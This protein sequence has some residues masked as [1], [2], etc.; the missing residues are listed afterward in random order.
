MRRLEYKW[1]VGI[2]FVLGLVMQLFDITIL[3]VA[4]ATLGREFQVGE[5][6]LQWVL[7]GYMISLAV[8]I[9]SSGWLA[10]RFGSKRTFQSAVVIF[11]LASVLC[12]LSTEMWMLIAAR[13]LQGVGGGMLVPVGQAMLFRA[14][15][16]NERAKASA[17]LAIPITVAPMLGPV[18]GGALVDYASWRWI[19]FINVPVGAIALAFTVIFLREERQ[20]RPGRFDFPGF[21]FAGGG[22]ACLLYGLDRGAQSGWGAPTVWIILGAAV[23]L[24]LALIWR[25]LNTTAPML[26]VRLLGNRMFGTGNALLMCSTTAMFSMLFLIPLYLQNLRGISPMTA[27]LTLTPQA[28][29]MLLVTQVIS[30][31]YGR[32]GPRRLLLLGFATQIAVA[33]GMQL[34]DVRTPLTLVV[35]LLLLQG[36]AM[37][38]LMTPLQTA[39]FA[40]V[41]P[42][43]MGHASSMFNVSRQVATALGTAI[44]ATVLVVLTTSGMSGVDPSAADQVLRVRMDA[45]NGAFIP[46]ALAGLLGFAISWLVR[47]SDAAATLDH[48]REPESTPASSG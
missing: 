14:F 15:P 23:V 28:L 21:V 22:L 19:F 27:G 7:T 5:G 8:F 3:N 13:V 29:M 4:L 16:A 42:T 41:S 1:L 37:G 32:V 47:D 34:L 2:T 31:V 44:V 24:I 17:V 33:A 30:R 26:N 6:T 10:D 38:L 39:A 43:S 9:P 36:T 48:P 35:G 11:T 12:G 18:L 45:Y 20:D 46:A 25:E 40:Q